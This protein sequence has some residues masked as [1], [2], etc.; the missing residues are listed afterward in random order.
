[1]DKNKFH[2]AELVEFFLNQ[3]KQVIKLKFRH[4]NGEFTSAELINVHAFRGEDLVLQNIIS[5][6]L[7]Y[8][9]G[10]IS[11]NHL[12]SHIEW[13]GNLSDC[14]SW[15]SKKSQKIWHDMMLNGLLDLV[16]FEPSAGIKIVAVCEKIE[17]K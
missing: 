5:R 16:I 17:F 12:A 11:K 15:I 1:M 2:D 9:L 8:S 3:E 4:E 7:I 10:D 13:V 6:V 14:K